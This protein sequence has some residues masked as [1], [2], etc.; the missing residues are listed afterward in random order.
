MPI[1]VCVGN[2]V[3][4]H[5]AFCFLWLIVALLTKANR[6]AKPSVG[7][8]VRGLCHGYLDEKLGCCYTKGVC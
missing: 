6:E 7:A 2:F 1:F 4:I 8:C 3:G 5:G